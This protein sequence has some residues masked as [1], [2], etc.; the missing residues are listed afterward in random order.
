MFGYCGHDSEIRA[1]A[2]VCGEKRRRRKFRTPNRGCVRR[3]DLRKEAVAAPSNGF[4]EAGTFGGVPQGVTDFAYRFIQAVIEVHESVRGPEPFL[5]FF[6][7][8]D[9]AGVFKQHRQDLEWL[10]LKPNAQAVLVQFAGAKIHLENSKT[11]LPV[12]LMV[13]LHGD[14]DLDREEVYYLPQITG[15]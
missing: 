9:L 7:S 11:E 1:I 2:K 5:K 10:F 13:F 4:H 3:F 15:T 6:A 8:Y 14:V 12:R